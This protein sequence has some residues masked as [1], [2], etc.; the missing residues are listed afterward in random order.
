MQVRASRWFLLFIAVLT[1][2]TCLHAAPKYLIRQDSQALAIAKA[3]FDA[4]G[5]APAVL[6]Y[7]DSVASGTVTI[8]SGRDPAAYPIMMKSKGLRE[9]RVELQMPSGTNLRIVNHGQGAIIRPDGRVKALDSNNTF[10]EHVNY[11]PLLSVLA[12]CSG[13]NVNVIYQGTADVQGQAEDI[14]EIDFIP[15]LSPGGG[16]IFASKSR[17]LFF[18]NQSTKLV[19][20]TQHD[21]FFEGNLAT[22]F[23]EEIY[24]ADYRSVNGMLVP[25]HQ[26][27]FIDG[28]LDTD[29]RLT[30]VNF[31]VGLSDSD[32]V[33]PEVR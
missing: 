17:T 22:T 12:D 14:V 27:L 16:P 25:F 5:G 24:Y 10:H 4:M 15:D 13:G 30:S 33:I 11:V 26:I 7:Q 23:S 31:N 19:D 6:A 9:T 21:T 8:Y 28:K 18:I 2:S 3:A 20:K 32:F 1:A 29:L